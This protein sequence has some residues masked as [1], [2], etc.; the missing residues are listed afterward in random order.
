MSNFKNP[1]FSKNEIN[2]HSALIRDQEEEGLVIS[3]TEAIRECRGVV[4]QS[5]NTCWWTSNPNDLII[6]SGR[7][8]TD[9][10]G[11]P[12]FETDNFKGWFNM[13][14]IKAHSSYGKEG[15]RLRNF[16]LAHSKNIHLAIAKM[17][18]DC[19]QIIKDF[20]SFVAFCDDHT[21]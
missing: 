19:K 13:D 11:S 2:P 8:P 1:Y 4:Y 17:P 5:A 10:F 6:K 3:F 16:M 14:A 20:T 9:V 12:L 15:R 18:E 21:I 7:V